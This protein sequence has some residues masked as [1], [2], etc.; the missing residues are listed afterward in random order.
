MIGIGVMFFVFKIDS[1]IAP[2]TLIIVY[3]LLLLIG[4]I[5]HPAWMS[6]MKDILP[7]KDGNTY[8]AARSRIIGFVALVGMLIAGFILD[9]FKQ[10]N[11]FIGFVILFSI[12]FI[13]R[14][15]S[16]YFFT[17]KYEPKFKEKDGKTHF[18]HFLKHIKDTNFGKYVLFVMIMQ[19]SVALASPFFAVYML[20]NLAFSYLEYT[21]VIMVPLLVILLVTSAW[22]KFADKYGNLKVLKISG[23]TI[24]FVPLLWLLS[25]IVLQINPE[26]IL[27]YLLII[28]VY[29]GIVWA[30]FNLSSIDFIYDVSSR[31]KV[32]QFTAIYDS[33]VS[34]GIFAGA[35]IGGIIASTTQNILWLS[36]ILFLFLL[37]GILRLLTA[38]TFISNIKEVRRVNDF[39]FKEAKGI[40]TNLNFRMVLKILR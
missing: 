29:S 7:K 35:L 30:G 28:E 19:F 22:G 23:W 25:P 8:L 34:V 40:F 36:P 18:R 6:W 26:F 5:A 2:V 10:S 37:S 31:Q 13:G 15:T 14:A 1:N 27:P 32:A 21:A 3:S 12:A 16:A 24:P 11:L 4:G 9:G 38:S 39:G 20:K 17:K 33:L